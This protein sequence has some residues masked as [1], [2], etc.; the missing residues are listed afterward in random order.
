MLRARGQSWPSLGLSRVGL[1]SLEFGSGSS[2]SS[3]SPNQGW[4]PQGAEARVPSLG[5]ELRTLWSLYTFIQIH[6]YRKPRAQQR[7]AKGTHLSPR[8]GPGLAKLSWV[9]G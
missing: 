8:D 3:G 5:W 1:R 7:R 9:K 4:L 6:K 2:A